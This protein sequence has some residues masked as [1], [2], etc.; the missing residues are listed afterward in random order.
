MKIALEAKT[1]LSFIDSTCESPPLDSPEYA[2]WKKVDCMVFS[3]ILNSVSKEIAESFI[4][5]ES[6]RALWKEIK[7][8]YGE[9]NAPVIYQI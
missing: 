9:S 5:A 1:K 8:R 3:W 2:V 4:Y 6:A 7:D